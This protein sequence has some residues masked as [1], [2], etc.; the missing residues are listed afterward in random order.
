[1]SN[2]PTVREQKKEM[3]NKTTKK[4]IL[5]E[6]TENIYANFSNL[7]LTPYDL[8]IS[9]GISDVEKSDNKTVVLKKGVRIIMSP[10]H[11]KVLRNIL[12]AA[13]EKYEKE[14]GKI[15]NVKEKK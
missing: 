1:M 5:P 15:P 3:T 11:A 12:N 14:I 8:T 6:D 4:I 10:Q 9:F 13:I 7:Y 2:K